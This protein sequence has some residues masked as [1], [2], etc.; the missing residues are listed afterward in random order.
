MG[1]SNVNTVG[2]AFLT[3]FLAAFLIAAVSPAVI[4]PTMLDQ[5]AKG[6][7]GPRLVPDRIMG[8]AVMNF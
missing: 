5:K 6:R 2:R 8:M 4:L 1:W 3:A 7:G